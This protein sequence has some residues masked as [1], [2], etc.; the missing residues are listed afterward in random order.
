MHL[1]YTRRVLFCIATIWI[2][3]LGAELGN[4]RNNGEQSNKVLAFQL[5]PGEKLKKLQWPELQYASVSEKSPNALCF[6]GGGSRSYIGAMGVLRALTNLGLMKHIRYIGGASGGGWAATAYTYFQPNTPLATMHIQTNG[7]VRTIYSETDMSASNDDQL[8]GNITAPSEI[9]QANLDFIA[10]NCLRGSVS[11]GVLSNFVKEWIKNGFHFHKAFIA[12][13]HQNY[14]LRA[15][16]PAPYDKV[17]KLF[18]YNEETISNIKARNPSLENDFIT[19]AAGRPV[20]TIGCTLLGPTRLIPFDKYNRTYNILEMN[21]FYIGRPDTD[22]YT[23]VSDKGKN[24]GTAIVGGMIESFAFTGHSNN[25]QRLNASENIGT[26]TDVSM[27]SEVFT[28]SHAAS[29]GGWA[30]ADEISSQL[31]PIGPI[32]NDLFGLDSNYFSTSTPPQGYSSESGQ[33]FALGDAGITE[34]SHLISLLR[35]TDLKGFVLI[36][37]TDVPMTASN[38]WD[39]TKRP[40]TTAEMDDTIP[41]YF[42]VKVDKADAPWDYSKNHV[43]E[44]S[45]FV[46]FCVAMQ[47]AIASG[48]GGVVF[49]ELNVVENKYWGIQGGYSVNVTWYLTSRVYNWEKLLPDFLKSDVIPSGPED[50]TNLPSTHSKY[51]SFPHYPTMDLQ[52]N[53]AQSNLLAN[54][55]G[56]VVLKNQDL[57]CAALGIEGGCPG[58]SDSN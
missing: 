24:S 57:F 21:P 49:M 23:Y 41:N 10:P 34:N 28:V 44:T 36:T 39:P 15:G 2:G 1:L 12:G 50:P 43:F 46:P 11:K 47:K 17:P 32:A 29:V 33:L 14:L 31:G 3:T 40:P 27:P 13:I 37:N 56:W 42:G 26:L 6:S 22:V 51:P 58:K 20:I 53:N 38:K 16:I 4:N 48:N 52:L 19:Q 7:S 54:L 55:M 8:L 45:Q 35:R 30:A 9:T 25:N 18:S 5:K